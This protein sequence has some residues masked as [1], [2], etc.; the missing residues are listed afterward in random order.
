[1]VS[2]G[3]PKFLTDQTP[4][5]GS[6]VQFD[7]DD[8]FGQI[9]LKS[10]DEADFVFAAVLKPDQTDGYHNLI[11]DDDSNRPMIWIDN[12][13]PQSYEANFGVGGDG[14]HLPP[15]N[16]GTDGWDIIILDSKSGTIYFNSGEA[17]HTAP[18]VAWAPESGSEVFDFFNRDG[19]ASYR[20]LVAE[21][22]VYN[23]ASAFGNDYAALYNEL[24]EKWIGDGAEITSIGITYQDGQVSLTWNSTPGTTYF[25]E[26]SSD[27]KKWNRV[28]AEIS[29]TDSTTSFSTEHNK[30]LISVFFRVSSE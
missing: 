6:V 30:G 27:L 19:G 28:S 11:D 8:H 21:L 26:S 9:E 23:G 2:E 5:G 16:S 14:P 22:R 29:A 12:R 20:G 4:L 3:Q 25:V 10:T 24:H 7:G 17:T 15:T 13:D 1:L 18:A